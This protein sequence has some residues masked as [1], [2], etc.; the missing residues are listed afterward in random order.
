M[1][2]VQ[3]KALIAS[4]DKSWRWAAERALLD[5][6]IT[7]EIAENGEEAE[8]KLIESNYSVAII[9]LYMRMKSAEDILRKLKKMEIRIPILVFSNTNNADD[10][11]RVLSEGAAGFFIKP[12]TDIDTLPGLVERYIS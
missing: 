3:K 10:R 2:N 12:K 11:R 7:V 4:D 5:N 1:N 6:Q 9:E 8:K